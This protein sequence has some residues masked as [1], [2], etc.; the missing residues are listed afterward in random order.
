MPIN[1]RVARFNRLVANHFVGPILTRLPGFGTIHHRGRKSGQDYRTP[2]KIFRYG[3]D[4]LVTLPYGPRSDWVRNVRAAGGCDLVTRGRRISLVRPRLLVDDGR[5]PIPAFARK[6]L[7]RIDA[8]TFLVLT[9][10]AVKPD[11]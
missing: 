11:G 5:A 6:V 2:V 1:H 3:D 9:P 10:G 7:S 8:K 4:Y